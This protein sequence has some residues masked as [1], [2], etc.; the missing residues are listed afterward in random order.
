MLDLLWLMALAA[1]AIAAYRH[2]VRLRL[3]ADLET[4]AAQDGRT[5]KVAGTGAFD[6]GLIDE[7]HYQGTLARIVARSR[8]PQAN[9]PCDAELVTELQGSAALRPVRVHIDGLVVG[10]LDAE[11]R[12]RWLT[13]LEHRRLPGHP[14]RVD[15]RIIGGWDVHGTVSGPFEVRLDLPGGEV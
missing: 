9:Q 3:A 15:A 7:T 5:E 8:T 11:A 6:A 14:L 1:L 10:Y 13:L 4:A 2:T 12:R